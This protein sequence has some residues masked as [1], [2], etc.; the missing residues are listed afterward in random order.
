VC[1]F[2]SPG[3]LRDRLVGAVLRGEK[4]ATSSLL[5]EWELERAPVP[6]K[7]EGFE[8]VAAWRADHERYW[9]EQVLPTLPARARAP[10]TDATP[11]VVEHFR[12]V[13]DAPAG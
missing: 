11:V 10:L 9:T 8:N 6:P 5:V 3:P 12:L 7:G 2:A 1:E 13:P 4:T